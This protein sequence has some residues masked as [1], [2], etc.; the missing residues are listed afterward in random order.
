MICI[1]Q[2]FGRVDEANVDKAAVCHDL[3]LKRQIRGRSLRPRLLFL[4]QYARDKKI[5]QTPVLHG[6]WYKWIYWNDLLRF[7]WLLTP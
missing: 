2:H 1:P 5:V 4:V 3:E 6:Q 7:G